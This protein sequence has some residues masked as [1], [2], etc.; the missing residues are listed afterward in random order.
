M[1][2]YHITLKF[3]LLHELFAKGSRDQAF[4]KFL[5]ITMTF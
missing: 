2:Q 3:K 4:S 5:M 1:A